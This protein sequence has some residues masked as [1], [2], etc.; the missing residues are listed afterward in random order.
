VRV[1]PALLSSKTESS[2]ENQKLNS[3]SR[4]NYCRQNKITGT[5]YDIA[6]HLWRKYPDKHIEW[7]QVGG[8]T[9]E[10]TI[11][12]NGRA[13]RIRISTDDTS[14]LLL[15]GKK[16]QLAP[17]FELTLDLARKES[18]LQSVKRQEKA[19]CFM[20]DTVDMRAIVQVAYGLAKEYGM[21][22]MEFTDVS[23][24]Y[25]PEE[26]RLGELSFLTTGRT[27]YESIL[28]QL[29][30]LN[31]KSLDEYRVRVRTNTWRTVGANLIDLDTGDIDI[32]APGSA[33]E[34]LS[35][36]KKDRS[37]CWFFHEY[38]NQLMLQSGVGSLYG[39]HWI[40]DIQ[41][42][43]VP[44]PIHIRLPSPRRSVRRY[45]NRAIPR[46]SMRYTRKHSK[47]PQT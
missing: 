31:C 27:W 5:E 8:H 9:E 46:L 43:T 40:C 37:F 38:M 12:Q 19:K 20:D 47:K 24:I 22:T 1:T 29:R 2:V 23:V 14:I 25:C 4:V 3:Y 17:C 41:P 6:L 13:I 18:V 26:V 34:V 32:D 30:C 28:P 16:P 39:S 15:G 33:M 45:H 42:R 11:L 7:K 35:L 21:H 10:R 36:M 44:Q